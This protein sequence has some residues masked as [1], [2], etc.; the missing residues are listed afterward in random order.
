MKDVF[1]SGTEIYQPVQQF[2]GFLFTR[3]IALAIILHVSK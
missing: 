2:A 3:V 1:N